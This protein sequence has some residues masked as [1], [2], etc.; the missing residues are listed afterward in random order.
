MIY[1]AFFTKRVIIRLKEDVSYDELSKIFSAYGEEYIKNITNEFT[2]LL[3][4]EKLENQLPLIQELHEMG[5]LKWGEPDFK[6]DLVKHADP[7]YSDQWHLNNT[8]GSIDGKALVSD[9]D[10]NAPEAW[11]ITTG[12]SNIVVAVIDGGVES[13]EDMRSLLPGYTPD[14]NGDGSPSSDGWHGQSVAGLIGA[15]HNNIGVKGI[16]PDVG[17]F[18]V[19]IL[20]NNTTNADVADGITWAVNQGADVLSN[21]WGFPSCTR[22]VASITA[23]FTDAATNGRGGLGCIILIASGNR[24]HSC[25]VYP[26]NLNNVTAVGAISGDGKRNMYSN[27]GSALDIVA[28]SDDDWRYGS[29]GEFYSTHGLRTIDREGSKGLTNDDYCDWIL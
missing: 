3:N 12:N 20:T 29:E 21:S 4:V 24:F 14:G 8:G 15:Q 18:S 1:R 22:N 10:A 9:I 2:Y 6:I 23:A 16:S 13:H 19:N 11:A 28:P 17:I 26:A 27:Y 25:V 5:V 7:M